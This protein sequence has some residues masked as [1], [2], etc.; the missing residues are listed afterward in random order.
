[1]PKIKLDIVT[2]TNL[3]ALNQLK[4][5]L[6]EVK[7]LASSDY[8]SGAGISAVE[9]QKTINS[10]NTLERALTAAY[11]AKLNTVNIE[12]FN[13]YL[14]KSKLTVQDLYKDLS[15]TGTVG[16]QAFIDM[17]QAS[18]S[19]GRSVKQTS[20]LVN[21]MKTTM[22]NTVKWGISSGLWNTMLSSVSKAWGYV[23]GL[24]AD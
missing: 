17:T 22:M 7:D 20:S 15:K 21:E 4:S 13:Q 11:D 12:K 14:H 2:Q 9:I 5:K 16:Q 1:M 6:K 24:N 10:V 3:Q 23:K 18:L 8:M 19:M